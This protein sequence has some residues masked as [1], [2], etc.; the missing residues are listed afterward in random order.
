MKHERCPV[1]LVE[2]RNERVLTGGV[3]EAQCVGIITYHYSDRVV[4]K[5]LRKQL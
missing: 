1:P 3:K 4:I 2:A 5:Y